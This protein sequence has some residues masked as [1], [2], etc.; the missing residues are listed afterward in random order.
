MNLRARTLEQRISLW[1]TSVIVLLI[2]VQGYF[3]YSALEQREDDLVD[4]MVL[5]ETRR[6]RD[7]IEAGDTLFIRGQQPVRLA[8][9]MRA[10]LVKPTDSEAQLGVPP[11]LQSQID[12]S[13]IRH[14]RDQVIHSSV[15]TTPV[16]RLII[17]YDASTNENFVYAFGS[18][19]LVAG[20]AFIVVGWALSIW[21]ARIVV[22]PIQRLAGQLSEWSPGRPSSVIGRSTEETQ[23]LEAFD[24]AQRR[25][26]EALA[27][28]REF[29][30]NL[31][32]EIRTPLTSLRSDAEILGISEA[33]RPEGVERLRRILVATDSVADALEA[34]HALSAARPARLEPV[35]LHTCVDRVWA[36]L[37][38]LNA[39]GRL[40]FTN[41]LDPAASP[42][43]LDRFAV[44]LVLRNLL[45]NAIEHASP[46]RCEARLMHRGVEIAD[47]GPGIAPSDLP[48][49]FDRYFNARLADVRPPN[50]DASAVE[51]RGLGL[52][53]ARQT[54]SQQG[55]R[56][57]VQSALGQG[58]KFRLDFQTA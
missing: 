14:V 56:L 40:N 39:D 41:R 38:H 29:A 47:T 20:V 13:Q 21:V 19:L 48:Q 51:L 43:M 37:Q 46:G 57:S 50:D 45:R 8:P 18:Y 28:E 1:M 10:W 31:R 6:V 35:N 17:E 58:A 53:I 30:A 9:H 32:H 36:S 44:M 52:A 2:A 26:D 54:A 11:E 15:S 24:G 49:I 25:V 7:R 34:A 5:S 4:E 42:L 12:G 16:G 3:A 55:W 33:L 23:L 22:A 27:R